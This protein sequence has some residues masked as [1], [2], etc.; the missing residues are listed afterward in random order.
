MVLKLYGSNLSTCCRRV[1]TVLKE[2]QV[3]YE[4]I[5]INMMKGEHKTTEYINKHPFGQI[6]YIVRVSLNPSSR[7]IS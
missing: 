1:V 3:P 7:H 4:L 5:E 6:P 2:K